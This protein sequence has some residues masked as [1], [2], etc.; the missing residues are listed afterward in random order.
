MQKAW[1]NA[2]SRGMVLCGTQD[3][4]S[5]FHWSALIVARAPP[6]GYSLKPGNLLE[7][8]GLNPTPPKNPN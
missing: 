2:C 4:E 6:G 3:G 7:N 8:L 5:V 1:N